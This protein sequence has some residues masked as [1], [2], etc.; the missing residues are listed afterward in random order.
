MVITNTRQVAGSLF[1]VNS[2]QKSNKGNKIAL[3]KRLSHRDR[4]MIANNITILQIAKI[5]FDNWTTAINGNWNT[6]KM[7]QETAR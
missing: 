6:Y 5:T 3:D 2:Q 7:T 1:G 4:D